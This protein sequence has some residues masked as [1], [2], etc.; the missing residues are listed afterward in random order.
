MGHKIFTNETAVIGASWL[1]IRKK[2]YFIILFML[3]LVYTDRYSC[4][5]KHLFISNN[6]CFQYVV[7][8]YIFVCMN[9]RVRR[10]FEICFISNTV[11]LFLF[12]SSSYKCS[13]LMFHRTRN[14]VFHTIGK[15]TLVSLKFYKT[16]SNFHSFISFIS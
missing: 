12:N 16:V 8:L 1:S 13:Q 15:T 3:V 11:N 7:T 9:K 10:E 5:I 2:I 14:A 4:F 6:S